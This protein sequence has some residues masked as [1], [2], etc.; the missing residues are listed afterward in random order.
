MFSESEAL[1]N[2]AFTLVELV[3]ADGLKTGH[4][5]KFRTPFYFD[6]DIS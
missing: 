3:E 2:S 1:I 4:F 6:H 5:D